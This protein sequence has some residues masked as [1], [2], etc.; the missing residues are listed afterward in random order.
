LA[1]RNSS[2]DPTIAIAFFGPGDSAPSNTEKLLDDFLNTFPPETDFQFY[3]PD[4]ILRAQKGLKGVAAWLEDQ[5]GE[6]AYGTVPK[7]DL[8]KSL[9]GDDGFVIYLP[10]DELDSTDEPI[11]VEAQEESVPVKRLDEG[12][13]TYI[14]AEPEKPA[15]EPAGKKRGRSRGTSR[16]VADEA[17]DEAQATAEVNVAAQAALRT[18]VVPSD[19]AVLDSLY[20]YIASRLAADGIVSLPKPTIYPAWCDDDG[21]YRPRVGRGRGRKGEKPVDLTLAEVEEIPGLL[22]EFDA[23]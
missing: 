15:D 4:K 7:A 1:R 13:D 22:A 3:L 19:T 14:L 16:S 5:F 6:E 2:P 11:I 17:P 8:V 23:E 12:L 20:S 10:A 9:T 18:L 21:N